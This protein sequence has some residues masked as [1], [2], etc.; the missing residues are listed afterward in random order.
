M[1]K[2]LD[3]EI[4][5]PIDVEV[6]FVMPQHAT[7]QNY[8]GVNARNI[9]KIQ[10]AVLS[11]EKKSKFKTLYL[12]EIFLGFSTVFIGSIF[13]AFVS[14]IDFPSW[15]AYVFYIACPCLF[16]ICLF[17]FIILR[18]NVKNSEINI[19]NIIKDNLLNNEEG[20]DIND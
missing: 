4:I 19:M 1:S 5:R 6:N 2:N 3:P 17:V 15:Q 12:P 13:S 20:G 16:L 7:H 14:G 10:K 11:I 8:I 18:I 9:E